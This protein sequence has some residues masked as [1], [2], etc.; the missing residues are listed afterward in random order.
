MKA[1]FGPGEVLPQRFL[2]V[3]SLKLQEWNIELKKQT[4]GVVETA[5]LVTP[6]RHKLLTRV[7]LSTVGFGV[8]FWPGS[9]WVTDIKL[10][11]RIASKTGTC[12]SVIKTYR[13]LGDIKSR[14]PACRW[15]HPT[16]TRKP[17]SANN[18]VA[19][20]RTVQRNKRSDNVYISY[21]VQNL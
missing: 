16:W 7:W 21:G 14:L 11:H 17:P 13:R 8:L 3:S 18:K 1:G 5:T 6:T 20:D 12:H 2:F 19:I 4:R 15:R 10:T 9:C